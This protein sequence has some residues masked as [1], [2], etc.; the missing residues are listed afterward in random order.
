MNT[1][2]KISH[3]TAWIKTYADNAGM[4]SL[5]VG[6]SG[7]IDSAVVSTLCAKTGATNICYQY[8]NQN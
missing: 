4:Q 7:G 1:Q 5:I 8:A 3:I 2:E 6:I